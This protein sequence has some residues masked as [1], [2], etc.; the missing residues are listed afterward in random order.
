M[1]TD[2][3]C[4]FAAYTANEGIFMQDK[5]AVGLFDSLID[6]C[7]VQWQQRT[8]VQD[9]GINSLRLTQMLSL[10]NAHAIRNNGKISTLTDKQ[11]LRDRRS[12]INT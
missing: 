4:Y 6:S 1:L 7:I 12:K 2:V 8:Q 9:V 5:H 3:S 10:M 11:S